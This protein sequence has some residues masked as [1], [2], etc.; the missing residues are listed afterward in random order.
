[1][2]KQLLKKLLKDFERAKTLSAFA[3]QFGIPRTTMFRIL[4]DQ[5]DGNIKVWEKIEAYYR[6][7]GK[8]C[9]A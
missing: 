2:R 1:M 7:S 4:H 8:K 3:R 9:S 6:R 5:N